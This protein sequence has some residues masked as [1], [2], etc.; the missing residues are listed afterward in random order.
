MR[1]MTGANQGLRRERTHICGATAVRGFGPARSGGTGL[2]RYCLL[3]ELEAQS[4]MLSD[5]VMSSGPEKSL[6]MTSSSVLEYL[7][8]MEPSEYIEVL[9]VFCLSAIP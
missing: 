9:K 4:M 3:S 1:S 8:L 6:N 2:I 5:C 7:N